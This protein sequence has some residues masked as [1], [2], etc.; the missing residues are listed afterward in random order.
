MDIFIRNV[1][2]PANDKHLTDVLRYPL[3]QLSIFAYDCKKMKNKG[4]AILTIADESLAASFMTIYGYR[5]N[6]NPQDRQA[7]R[8]KTIVFLQR[9]LIFTQS[10]S[11]PDETLLRALKLEQKVKSEKQ[12]ENL[13][14]KLGPPQPSLQQKYALSQLCCGVWDYHHRALAYVPYFQDRRS[15]TIIFGKTSLVIILEASNGVNW[16]CRIDI[17]YYSIDSITTGSYANP[18]IALTLTM[19]PR[20]YRLDPDPNFMPNDLSE[21]M[22]A[23]SMS[24]SRPSPLQNQNQ[25]RTRITSI[26]LPHEQIVGSCFVYQ[27]VLSNFAEIANVYQLL[28]RNRG[29]PSSIRYD[30]VWL[31]PTQDL[32]TD[33]RQ[34]NEALQ[35]AKWP[36][37]L[38]FQVQRLATNGFLRPKKVLRLLPAITR[39]S[40]I[41]G[42]HAATW[43][44]Q[45]VADSLPIPGPDAAPEEF[46]VNDLIMK[47]ET[48]AASWRDEGSVY[49]LTKR[50]QHIVLV[51]K[52]FI[53]PTGTYLE[54]PEME[55]TN[56]VLRNYSKHTD[57]FIRTTFADETYEPVHF[58]PNASMEEIF[59]SRFKAVLDSSINIAGYGF[60][61]LGFS[62]SSL[63]SQTCWFMAPFIHDQELIVAQEVVK[64]LGDFSHIR[65]PA[66][67]AARIGQA[68][69]DT[70]GVVTI[71]EENLEPMYDVTRNGRVFSDGVGTISP[72]LLKR[73]WIDYAMSRNLKPTALQI[74]FGGAKGML[75][76]D[77]TI[78]SEVIRLRESMIKFEGSPSLDLE[79]CGANFKPLPMYLNR[80]FIKILED[81][82]VDEDVFL[83]LQSVAVESI[84]R[85][86]SSPVNAAT[87]L[88]ISRTGLATKTPSLIRMLNDMGLS[89]HNDDFLQHTV[90]IA[91]LV[92][93]REIKHR[94]R[95]LVEH[96]VT[97][98]GIMDETGILKEGEIYCVTET[99]SGGRRVLSG[100]KVVITRAP[101]L[102]PGDVQVVKA[103]D[104]PADSPLNAL[105]NCV[106]FSQHGARDL[107]SC[108]SGG[109]LDGDL[110]NVI[111]DPRLIPQTTYEPA[112][113]PRA[114]AL[115][116]G[117]EVV[118]QDMTDFFI[119]F[120]ETDQLGR[121]STLH[122]VLADRYVEGTL[123]PNCILLAELAST[124]V[125]FS[126][127]GIPV[128]IKRIP[129]SIN[130]RPDF[131][132]PGPRVRIEDKGTI[133]E[134]EADEDADEF[135]D[136]V[137][138]LDPDSR[139]VRYYE[140]D[141][142]LGKLYRAID[143]RAILSAIQARSKTQ[144][145]ALA[146]AT[147]TSLMDKV[148]VH[149]KRNTALVQYAHHLL[150][151][152]GMK[153]AYEHNLADMMSTYSTHPSQ[154]LS[155]F[156][157]FSGSILGKCAG[158]QNKRVRENNAKMK[159][160]FE[161]DVTFWVERITHGDDGDREEALAR[162]IAALHVGMEEGSRMAGK[163]RRR[164][165]LRSW[166]Y[167]AAAVCLKEVERFQG[168]F[169]GA[170]R[171]VEVDGIS[172][173][174]RVP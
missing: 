38:K 32:T 109:D 92:A 155:E 129:R 9:T 138:S 108:L 30:F 60:T 12:K 74:R 135:E 7:Q 165:E 80:Q 22:A 79:I 64:R 63:R 45:Q 48:T 82:G 148:W 95:I 121:I 170:W 97:L 116:I 119:K 5:E 47:L 73:V 157:V 36:F 41:S 126:K 128:D 43:A 13:V 166:R 150:A 125:D 77:T 102:H 93:L 27:I 96:G 115:D 88:E 159:E 23:L 54:G 11:K 8:A 168:Q 122:Q 158:A 169:G 167:I 113:Y 164:A 143:E 111:Y 105:H 132:A 78:S 65:S 139:A 98:Y 161:R 130:T 3:E 136:P 85:M 67:C 83:E 140:S 4:C 114:K 28:D 137:R 69:S 106:V 58:D 171:W 154:P 75:S 56:R 26:E 29:L 49:D 81:L 144:A 24:I 87:F 59:H 72:K 16:R 133:F 146:D 18:A 62:H 127:T 141:K 134:D 44:V 66:K 20:M 124:A 25:K 131:M 84:R 112:D 152:R 39:V 33:M 68:F 35:Y 55:V 17:P 149:V 53:T 153:E 52:V 71:R 100:G 103:V 120:M 19:A 104:V 118:R 89:F 57:Q 145:Q 160:Q 90:E 15:G 147:A 76:L 46:N 162:S 86:T 14:A 50:H 40:K 10:T 151:A 174:R 21:I 42:A 94:S 117:R 110:Y 61:F 2:I 156:E 163:G 172:T 91:A 37:P 123:H 1:A 101:A 142:V 34:L 173:L 70:N 99:A 107:P 51:H 31:P 6:P